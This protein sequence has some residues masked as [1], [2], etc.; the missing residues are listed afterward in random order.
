MKPATVR[1]SDNL[2]QIGPNSPPLRAEIMQG[3]P[4]EMNGTNELRQADES[5][6]WSNANPTALMFAHSATARPDVAAAMQ[7][8]GIRALAPLPLAS[9]GAALAAAD[10]AIA[11]LTGADDATITTFVEQ[12]V[13]E[14][15]AHG[16]ALIATLTPA[17][18]DLVA[19]DLLPIGAELLCD[20][21]P[22]DLRTAL[23][24]ATQ[25]PTR[26]LHDSSRGASTER[27]RSLHQDVTR[28]AATLRELVDPEAPRIAATPVP[29]VGAATIRALIRRRRLRERFFEADLFADPAW[30]ILLD[31]YAAYLE[32]GRVCVSSLCYAAAVPPTTA[33][34]WIGSMCDSGLLERHADAHDK[35]RHFIHLTDRAIVGMNGYFLTLASPAHH[36]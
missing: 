23:E 35:R 12:T 14:L 36:A 15:D 34:R 32:G 31:L 10:L 27:L 5:T 4:M 11:D 3:R 6:D 21:A 30:D 22:R 29:S 16:I 2:L 19:L 20:P 28:L 13:P 1:A 18:I 26:R 7:H 9:G 17:Q 24:R 33:L 8:A 25:R